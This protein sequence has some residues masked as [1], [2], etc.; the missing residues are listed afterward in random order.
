MVKNSP[1]MQETQFRSLSQE[2]PLEKRTLQPTPILLPGKSH[3]QKSLAALVQKVTK[4]QGG[5]N[6]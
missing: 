3:G 5:Q 6:D 2:D 4:S 1:V